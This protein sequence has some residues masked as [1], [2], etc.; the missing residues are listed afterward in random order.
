MSVLGE[1]VSLPLLPEHNFRRERGQKGA[2]CVIACA[3]PPVSRGTCLERRGCDVID[4]RG[5]TFSDTSQARCK[6]QTTR[7]HENV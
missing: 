5:R 4:G 1:R 7:K 6:S 3:R 2:P